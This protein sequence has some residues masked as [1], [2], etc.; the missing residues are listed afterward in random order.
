MLHGRSLSD[1]WGL[2]P[3]THPRHRHLHHFMHGIRKHLKV[4]PV[5]LRRTEFV[6]SEG[7]RE[8]NN[9]LKLA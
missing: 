3:Q 1:I 6:I 4:K 9:S 2:R 7:M 5:S 8:V